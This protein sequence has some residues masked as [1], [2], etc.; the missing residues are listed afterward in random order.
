MS[1]HNKKNHK[2]NIIQKALSNEQIFKVTIYTF[3]LIDHTFQG[4][5][6]SRKH[7]E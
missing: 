4:A 5:L 1:H 7:M 2:K 3:K 6:H